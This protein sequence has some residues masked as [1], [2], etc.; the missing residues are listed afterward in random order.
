MSRN[1][2]GAKRLGTTILHENGPRFDTRLRR[3][4]DQF[5]EAAVG[6]QLYQP[7]VVQEPAVAWSRNV[8]PEPLTKQT[9]I[10]PCSTEG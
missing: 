10:S 8:L 5:L 2:A 3:S 6:M 4:I 7:G 9:N 1:R